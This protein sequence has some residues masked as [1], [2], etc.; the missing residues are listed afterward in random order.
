MSSS[1][2][3]LIASDQRARSLSRGSF[4][5]SRNS[6]RN[7]SPR[8]SLDVPFSAPLS[9]PLLLTEERERQETKDGRTLTDEQ[10]FAF[11]LGHAQNDLSSS[12]WFTY[13]LIYLE[14]LRYLP[15]SSSGICM[16]SGQI[17]DAI[18][19]PIAG[20][21]SDSGL[22][23]KWRTWNLCPRTYQHLIAITL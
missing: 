15:P 22:G 9:Q 5:S 12:L 14:T 20:L 18:S 13:L 11:S 10:T 3:L 6:S 23:V 4:S 7:N 17:F 21:V 16:L 19:T 8:E 1:S 2:D